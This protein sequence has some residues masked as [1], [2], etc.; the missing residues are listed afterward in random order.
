[1]LNGLRSVYFFVADLQQSRDWYAAVLGAPPAEDLAD[2][3]RFEVHGFNLCL[4]RADEK[5]PLSTGGEVAYWEVDDFDAAVQHFLAH[6]GALHRG[7]ICAIG[8]L[9][10]CQIRDPFGNVIGLEGRK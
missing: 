10:I 8:D 5:S 4:H 1:M 2:F 9:W 7:P 3:V 6:G